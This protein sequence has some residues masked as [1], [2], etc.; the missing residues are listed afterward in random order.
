M[1]L[2]SLLQTY[3]NEGCSA[4]SP[5]MLLKILMYG[6]VTKNYSSRL[7]AK[8]VKENIY[9]IW[10]AGGNHPTRNVIN[11]FRGQKMQIVIEEVFSEMLLILADRGYIDLR[12]LIHLQIYKTT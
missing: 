4:Y 6:Y 9:F 3:S 8:A 5:R 2:D 12:V 10:L 7:M 1:N 11:S